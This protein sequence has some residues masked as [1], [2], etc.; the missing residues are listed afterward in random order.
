[1]SSRESPQEGMIL[2]VFTKSCALYITSDLRVEILKAY[3]QVSEGWSLR[4]HQSPAVS[5][6]SESG[7][8]E[9]EYFLLSLK[10][11]EEK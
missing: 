4:R 1:M 11:Q 2:R 10:F 7:L 9:K 6:Y 3:L 5:H 8:G